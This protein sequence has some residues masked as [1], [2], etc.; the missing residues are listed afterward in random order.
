M[1]S[2]TATVG[3]SRTY[4]VSARPESTSRSPSGRPRIFLLSPANIAGIRAGYVMRE[5]ANSEL[6]RSLRQGGVSLGELFS[7]ISGLYFRGKLAYAR[8][9]AGAPAGLEGAFVITASGGLVSPD[10]R[11]T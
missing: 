8:T 1:F 11:V 3:Q 7:F 2:S 5:S 9:F 10:T 4:D 6:A